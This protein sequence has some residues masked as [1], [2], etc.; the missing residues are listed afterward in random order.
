METIL[1]HASICCQV[2]GV[3]KLSLN[4]VMT[5]TGQVL[6]QKSYLGLELY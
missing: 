1:Q 3:Q 2:I 6:C 4:G 5:N